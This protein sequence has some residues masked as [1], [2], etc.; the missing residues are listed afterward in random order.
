MTLFRHPHLRVGG[1]AVAAFIVLLLLGAARG[2]GRLDSGVPASAP[3]TTLPADPDGGFERR[4]GLPRQ[5]G[6]DGFPGG[7]RGPGGNAPG[8]GTAPD[9]G[10][11]PAPGTSGGGTT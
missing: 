3:E 11:S 9:G 5:R 4:D 10:L 8:G 7:G 1:A 6:G 2:E